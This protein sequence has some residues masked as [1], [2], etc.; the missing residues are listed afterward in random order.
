VC[1]GLADS[2]VRQIHWILSGALGRGVVWQWISVN[3]AE[4]ASK[5]PLPH[6]DPRPPS[7]EEA[8]RLVERAW[9]KDPDWGALVWL[10]MT[11]GAR[12]REICG[13]RW[14][15]VD[16]DHVMITIRRTVYLDEHGQLQQKDTKTHQQR[17]VVLDPRPQ[18]YSANTA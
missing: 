4:H 15:H 5:P 18:R 1:R 2:T 9:S 12:R 8:A 17:R 13:L 3:P 11:T 10:T 14:S 16:L 6:P 7:A